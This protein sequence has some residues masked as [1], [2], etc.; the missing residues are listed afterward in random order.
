[1]SEMEVFEN[2]SIPVT[3][4]LEDA[5]TCPKYCDA[6]PI[7]RLLTFYYFKNNKSKLASL[8]SEDIRNHF[9]FKEQTTPKQLTL[10]DENAKEIL[11]EMIEQG[12]LKR[13]NNFIGVYRVLVDYFRYPKT[14]S[15]FCS[16]IIKLGLK[17]KDKPL[18]YQKLYDGIQ[19]G[20]QAPS[21]LGKPYK[22]WEKYKGKEGENY[23]VFEHHKAV[24]D[25][26]ISILREKRI[27]QNS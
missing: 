1:M 21:I 8:I 7:E 9:H 12:I 27:L 24:A 22:E 17:L 26:L 25:A 19:K 18:N 11:T 14:Y 4:C 15:H 23:T 3:Y 6:M 10:D 20:M 13:M 16:C 2:E 5:K